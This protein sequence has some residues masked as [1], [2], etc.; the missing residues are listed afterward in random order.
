[1]GATK[2]P[3]LLMGDKLNFCCMHRHPHL[4]G[5]NSENQKDSAGKTASIENIPMGFDP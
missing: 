3:V 1:M 2:R 4:L 5:G